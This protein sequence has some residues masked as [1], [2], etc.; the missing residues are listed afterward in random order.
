MDFSF[1]VLLKSR[2]HDIRIFKENGNHQPTWLQRSLDLD[3]PFNW[4]R[5]SSGSWKRPFR[6]GCLF[7]LETSI[8][9]ILSISSLLYISSV[10]PNRECLGMASVRRALDSPTT[11]IGDIASAAAMML[12]AIGRRIY[13]YVRF[14]EKVSSVNSGDR[15][16]E[17][18]EGME[19][20][21]KKARHR[22]AQHIPWQQFEVHIPWPWTFDLQQE[23]SSSD[24][25]HELLRYGIHVHV[26]FQ[27]ARH[28]CLANNTTKVMV[29]LYTLL[30]FLV[31]C[32]SLVLRTLNVNH[33]WDT[34]FCIL[35]RLHE[36]NNMRYSLWVEN[37]VI[38][39]NPIDDTW[40]R[41]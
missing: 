15:S 29:L 40:D 25:G 19:D 37:F 16:W 4:V 10:D 28:W 39:E 9:W 11:S 14:C 26:S 1:L 5:N 2:D 36:R 33:V 12:S 6:R 7:A 21:S 8:F 17:W 3:S 32:S 35:L 34:F 20:L 13:I 27:L 30:H 41:Q 38:G 18:V 22:K 23:S 24:H 31:V